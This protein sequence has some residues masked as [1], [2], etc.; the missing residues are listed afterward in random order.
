MAATLPVLHDTFA[1][2]VLVVYASLMHDG[3][4]LADVGVRDRRFHVAAITAVHA[5]GAKEWLLNCRLGPHSCVVTYTLC[6]TYMS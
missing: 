3:W 2:F 4:V 5:H 1:A 6:S